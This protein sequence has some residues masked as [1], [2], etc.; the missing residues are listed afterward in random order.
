MIK[1]RIDAKR[2]ER[3]QHGKSSRIVGPAHTDQEQTTSSALVAGDFL[4][5]IVTF[6]SLTARQ[7]RCEAHLITNISTR[8][9]DKEHA[10]IRDESSERRLLAAFPPVG[11]VF[12]LARL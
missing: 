9:A 4:L 6:S 12:F 11:V 2:L 5:I 8:Q 7:K 3:N 1:R 10:R